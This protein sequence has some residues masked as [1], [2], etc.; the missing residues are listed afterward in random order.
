MTAHRLHIARDAGL[1]PHGLCVLG[2]PDAETALA[3]DGLE[4][5][6][7]TASAQAAGRL[8]APAGPDH[9]ES[10][11]ATLVLLPR[12]KALARGWIAAALRL[13]PDAVLVDG[14]KTDGIESIIRDLRAQAALSVGD[15]ISKAHGKLVALSGPKDGL[16]A[17]ALPPSPTEIASG[18]VTVPGVFS[19]DGID[20]AS[21]LL[22][23]HL[24]PLK[25]EGADLGA[26]WGYL[27]T[28][29]MAQSTIQRLHLV[30]D[31][32]RAL[33]CARLNLASRPAPE[34]AIYH[35]ADVTTWRAP[36]PLDF[37]VMNPPFHSG[38][39]ADPDLGRAFID[40]AARLLGPSGRLYLVA[41]RHLPYETRLTELFK[42][43]TDMGGD[44]RFKLISADAPKR[45]APKGGARLARPARSR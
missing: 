29:L 39:A 13:S 42:N 1:L 18:L 45:S 6:F 35:W 31:D 32:A 44:A 10:A 26:G 8:P 14:Q 40:S 36:R 7:V 38:R 23:A 4:P 24:P 5:R 43:V 20:P 30:E 41:N 11:P 22:A 21:A 34:R 9:P 3:L 16:S 19:A 37:I 27:A 25:G 33:D 2:T 17:W 12:S 28:E 15:A